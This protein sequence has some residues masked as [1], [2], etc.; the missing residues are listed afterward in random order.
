[1]A[2]INAVAVGRVQTFMQM[3]GEATG[4][5]FDPND[6]LCWDELQFYQ[7]SKSD[8]KANGWRL[9]NANYER[10][11]SMYP[12]SWAMTSGSNIEFTI[13]APSHFY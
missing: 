7:F 2:K 10:F 11:L 1:M 12:L 4:W 8:F 5:E 6:W 9:T 3:I 13:E